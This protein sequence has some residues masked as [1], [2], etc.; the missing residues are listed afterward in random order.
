MVFCCSAVTCNKGINKFMEKGSITLS[1]EEI[2][3]INGRLEFNAT[4]EYN[5]EDAKMAD[6][7]EVRFYLKNS[8][9]E[10][11]LGS[12][13]DAELD[14]EPQARELK[15]TFKTTWFSKVPITEIE[16]RTVIYK[17][18]KLRMLPGVVVGRIVS[19]PGDRP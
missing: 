7:L 14:K 19:K 10:T 1:P 4:M 11:L 12:I 6:S 2:V 5:T 3:N 15:K 8:Q 13:K 18:G 9:I 16:A 17:K